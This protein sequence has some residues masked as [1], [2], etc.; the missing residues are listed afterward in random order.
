MQIQ[1]HPGDEALA[2]IADADPEALGDSGMSG[3]LDACDRCRSLV[4]DLRSLRLALTAMP[5]PAVTPPRPLRLLPTVEPRPATFA[6]RVGAVIRGAFAPVMT[7]GAALALVGVVGTSGITGNFAASGPAVQ[8]AA[9]TAED[10][11]EEG[12]TAAELLTPTPAAEAPAPDAAAGAEGAAT[13]QP[14]TQPY[15]VGPLSADE[16]AD[17]DLLDRMT[18]EQPARVAPPVERAGPQDPRADTASG[19][20]SAGDR[21]ASAE[22]ATDVAADRPIWPMLLFSGVALMVAALILRWIFQPRPA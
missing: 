19:D 1:N 16:T 2:R 12:F 18:E 3:H 22:P 13:D 21:A 6:D 11:Q 15:Q 8:D 14:E 5:D 7:A 9:A 17:P 10:G 4:D 20:A